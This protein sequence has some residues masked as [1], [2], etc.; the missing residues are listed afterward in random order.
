[1]SKLKTYTGEIDL[2][3]PT[4]EQISITDIFHSLSNLCRFNGACSEFY[5]VA[6][7]SC[8]VAVVVEP[9]L[10]LS[11]LLHDAAE[12]YIGDIATPLKRM[13]PMAREIEDRILDVIDKK[14]NVQTRHPAIKQADQT[15]FECEMAALMSEDENPP[16]FVKCLSPEEARKFISKTWLKFKNDE[17]KRNNVSAVNV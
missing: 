14:F 5:S 9:E 15:V 10:Q 8:M 4:M 17:Y 16:K 2:I 12:A 11:A 1:M 13:L 7:H 3:H 6:Q